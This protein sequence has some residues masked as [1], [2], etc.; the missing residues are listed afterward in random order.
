MSND[1]RKAV[2][3][4][5]NNTSFKGSFYETSLLWKYDSVK[6]P[7]SYNMALSRW[8][9]LEKKCERD[10]KLKSICSPK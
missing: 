3:Q 6:L 9:C 7:S 5:Q 1:D 4:L 8:S 2:L 10:P